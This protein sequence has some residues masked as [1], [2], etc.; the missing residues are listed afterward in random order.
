[1]GPV[2]FAKS[3]RVPRFGFVSVSDDRSVVLERILAWQNKKPDPIFVGPG[4]VRLM[5]L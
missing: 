1:M 3:L 5:A 2:K 4:Q